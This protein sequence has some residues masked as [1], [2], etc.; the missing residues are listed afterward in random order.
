MEVSRNSYNG[1][2][3]TSR[4]ENSIEDNVEEYIKKHDVTF[5]LPLESKITLGARN[6]DSDEVDLKLNFG[7]EVEGQL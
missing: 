1:N 4:S 5:K 6:L 3:V 7:G 2:E